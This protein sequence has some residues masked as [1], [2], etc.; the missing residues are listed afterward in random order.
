MEFLHRHKRLFLASG[1]IICFAAIIITITGVAPGSFLGRVFGYVV[2]PMQRA[3]SSAT[4]WVGG[5]FSILARSADILAENEALREENTRLLNEN[6]RLRLQEEDN[7]ALSA[8]LYM[9]Q[10]YPE[11]RK[12][13]AR[14][15]GQNPNH[16]QARFT[17]DIGE[18]HGVRPNMIVLG[19][20]GLFGVIRQTGANHS[21]VVSIMDNSFAAAV[22]NT[23]TEDIAT[24]WGDLELSQDGLMII[25]RIDSAASFMVGDE[26]QTS[27]HGAFFPPGVHVGYVV[28]VH[29]NPDGHTQHAIVEPTANLGRLDTV[30]VVM[31]LFGDATE[32]DIFDE[33]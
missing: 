25:P 23:R 11:L 20:G 27:D 30:L 28:S 18:N 19:D 13:G 29:P 10:R 15:I 3:A 16:W 32:A 26:I 9:Y 33:D 7:I 1:I 6:N 21:Q 8:M 2:V 12:V 17:I 14:M 31:E 5:R 22:R 4:T 24:I